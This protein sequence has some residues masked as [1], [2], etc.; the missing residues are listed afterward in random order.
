MTRPLRSTRIT[1]LHHYYETVRPRCPATV[2]DLLRCWPLEDLPLAAGPTG[3]RQ[4]RGDRFPRSAQEPRSGSRRLHAGRHLGSQQAPPRLVPEPRS[5]PGFDATGICYDTSSAVRSRS[6]S[7]PH[8]TRSR[9]AFSRSAHHERHLTDA[10]CGGL[11]PPPA[12]RPRRTYLHLLHSTASS[13]FY[14]DA[15]FGVRGTRPA[16]TPS[17]LAVRIVPSCHASQEQRP[18]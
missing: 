3:R 2:L 9:R 10:A 5:C 12:G 11:E 16:E 1:G 8:L 7:D 18:N 6:P 17:L 13:G 4:C 14:I 15:S